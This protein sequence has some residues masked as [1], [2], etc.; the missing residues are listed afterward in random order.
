[1][2]GTLYF[3]PTQH[4]HLSSLRAV[5]A[6]VF[7]SS[8]VVMVT[9]T[10]QTLQMK[11]DAFTVSLLVTRGDG[12]GWGGEGW[13]GGVSPEFCRIFCSSPLLSSSLA[14]IS[15]YFVWRT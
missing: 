4:V 8:G 9:M 15:S 2:Y 14:R 6:G 12:G 5:L 11:R 1:M 3:Q 13:V 10:V 7:L